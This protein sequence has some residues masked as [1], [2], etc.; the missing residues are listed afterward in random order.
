MAPVRRPPPTPSQGSE[1]RE[2]GWP[3][4]IRFDTDLD[5]WP[6]ECERGTIDGGVYRELALICSEVSSPPA[7]GRP[8]LDETGAAAMPTI[9]SL[10]RWHR[11]RF[12]YGAEEP[13]S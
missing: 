4:P 3:G 1:H 10:S 11:G 5:R 8:T 9:L 7:F 12:F 6:I 13:V 2:A